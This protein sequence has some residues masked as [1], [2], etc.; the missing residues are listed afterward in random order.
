VMAYQPR[1]KKEKLSLKSKGIL[2]ERVQTLHREQIAKYKTKWK[3]LDEE[4]ATWELES[5]LRK[6]LNM[7]SLC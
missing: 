7:P 4:E 2:E 5:F 1:L 6:H 3:G